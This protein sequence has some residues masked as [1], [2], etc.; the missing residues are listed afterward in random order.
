M[1]HSDKKTDGFSIVELVITM[2]VAATA[3]ALVTT[4]YSSATRLIDKSG[5]FVRANEI[6]YSKL[7]EVENKPFDSI[8][9]S[10]TPIDFTSQLPAGLPKPTEG[11]IY[12]TSMNSADSLKYVFVRVKYGQGPNEY[13]VEYGDFVQKGGLGR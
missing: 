12:V 6:A 9:A 11:H 10:A 5:D 4:L 8:I 2:V 7:Q 13:M 1:Q 3:V